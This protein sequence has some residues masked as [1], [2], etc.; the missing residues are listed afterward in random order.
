MRIHAAL[1]VAPPL[2]GLLLCLSAAP[3][4]VSGAN[5]AGRPGRPAAP[6]KPSTTTTTSKPTVDLNQREVDPHETEAAKKVHTAEFVSNSLPF[7]APILHQLQ[8]RFAS[9]PHKH[10]I[11]AM[12]DEQESYDFS[13]QLSCVSVARGAPLELSF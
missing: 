6:D 10:H 9:Q 13:V 5:S 3:S 7:E 11:S 4:S 1:W 8:A 2:V 12:L